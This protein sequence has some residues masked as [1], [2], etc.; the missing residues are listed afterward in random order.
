MK[1]VFYGKPGIDYT[2][3]GF[4]DEGKEL[5][6]W[7]STRRITINKIDRTMTFNMMSK[8]MLKIF[9]DMVLD[10]VVVVKK[11]KTYPRHY[12]YLGLSDEEYEKLKEWR[13]KEVN[14]L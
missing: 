1:Y 8:E 11:E 5:V 6:I 7:R 2:K 10:G 9:M 12:H 4:E 3:Y 14:E 13:A